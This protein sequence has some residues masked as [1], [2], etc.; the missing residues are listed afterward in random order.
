VDVILFL[1]ATIA[2]HHQHRI[3]MSKGNRIPYR[4]RDKQGEVAA[5]KRE[6][7]FVVAVLALDI[8]RAMRTYQELR[9]KPVRVVATLSAKRRPHRKNTGD[10]ERHVDAPLGNHQ[11]SVVSTMAREFNRAHVSDTAIF[12]LSD[13][14]E[15]PLTDKTFAY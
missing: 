5:I 10:R 3:L 9:A 11:F 1:V 4:W 2:Q 7:P 8:N 13:H 15:Q 12:G 14:R 6:R